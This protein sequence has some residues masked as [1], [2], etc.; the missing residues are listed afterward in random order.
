MTTTITICDTCK[1]EDWDSAAGHTDGEALAELV[2]ALTAE[3][4]DV[5][6]RRHSCLMG[7][8][9]ACN[10]TLQSPRK[11]AYTLGGFSPSAETAAGL[12]DYAVRHAASATGVVP[13]RDWPAAIKGH[14][15]TRHPPL[16]E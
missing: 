4:P 15:I 10:V 9:R 6:M 16:P 8:S 1:R 7:C 5:R 12:V 2:E 14:F 3:V 11:M 13:Y